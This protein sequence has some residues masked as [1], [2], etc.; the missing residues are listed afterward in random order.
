M[1]L[2]ILNQLYKYTQMEISFGII[3]LAIVNSRPHVLHAQ[4]DPRVLRRPPQGHRHPADHPFELKQGRGPRPHPGRPEDRPGLLDEVIDAHP[5]LG[6]PE[7]GQERLMAE[8]R[9]AEIQ[10]Q[11]ILDMR[12]QRLDRARAREDPRGVPERAQGHRLVQGDPGERADRAEH[13]QERAARDEKS[14]RRPAA[15]GNR[16]GDARDFDRGH[17]HRRGHGGHHLQPRLHQAQPD[18]ALPQPAARR[19]GRHRHGHPRGRFR[20]AALRGLDPPHLPVFQQPRQGLL[21]QVLRHSPRP[22][23]S[24]SA[25]PSSTCSTWK[26]RSG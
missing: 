9:A 4:G 14:V 8:L 7:R 11:A 24:V 22:A 13:H 18:H 25:R 19:Q 16:R 15:D 10:A 20:G 26:S 5:L 23:G 21:V 6:R 17:D 1:A 12:L 2:V 3:L